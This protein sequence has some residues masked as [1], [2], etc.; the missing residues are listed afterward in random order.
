MSALAS[1]FTAHEYVIIPE[2]SWWNA[3]VSLAL[4]QGLGL[5]TGQ[6]SIDD[7]LNAMDAAWKQGPS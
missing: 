4:Q 2:Q 5:I 7:V 3:N 6:R 1:V